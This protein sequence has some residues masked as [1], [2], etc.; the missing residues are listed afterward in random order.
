MSMPTHLRADPQVSTTKTLTEFNKERNEN[1][2]AKFGPQWLENAKANAKAIALSHV[3]NRQLMPRMARK[4]LSCKN[5]IV[6]GAGPSLDD[7]YDEIK[8]LQAMQFTNF[9]VIAVDMAYIP[10]RKAGIRPDIVLSTDFDGEII[11]K[12]LDYPDQRDTPCCFYVSSHPKSVANWKGPK[13]FYVNQVLRENILPHVPEIEQCVDQPSLGNV[14]GTAIIL[15]QSWGAKRIA[16]VGNDLC[17]RMLD[18]GLIYNY[19]ANTVRANRP[20]GRCIFEDGQTKPV[21]Y[22]EHD[23]KHHDIYERILCKH[24]ADG[25]VVQSAIT[26]RD[27]L[28]ET[29]KVEH[30]SWFVNNAH[31]TNFYVCSQSALL[32]GV[33]LKG[34]ALDGKEHVALRSCNLKDFYDVCRT[35]TFHVN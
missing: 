26:Y 6:C 27:P 10:L 11:P 20:D 8:R 18:D 33:N 2:W 12:C 9:M 13:V 5:Y 1:M 31:V 32:D 22:D 19:C 23:L 3:M 21:G 35:N 16:I 7:C 24:D 30:L 28:F 34:E 15:A 4:V 29:Y 17:Y 14:S 25:R